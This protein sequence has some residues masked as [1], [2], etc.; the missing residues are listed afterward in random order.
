[1]GFRRA[2]GRRL[3]FKDVDESDARFDV[4]KDVVDDQLISEVETSPEE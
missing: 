3:F 2:W 4:N 1:M